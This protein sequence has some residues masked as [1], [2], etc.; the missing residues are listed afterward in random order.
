LDEARQELSPNDTALSSLI[1]VRNV[2]EHFASLSVERQR[3]I[4][5]ALLSEVVIHPATKLGRTFDP[6]RIEPRWRA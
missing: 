4:V 6:N 2:R 5:K 3:A 1:G